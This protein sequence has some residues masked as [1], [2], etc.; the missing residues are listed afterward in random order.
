MKANLFIQGALCTLPLFVQAQEKPNI[1]FILADDMRGSALNFLGKESIHTPNINQLATDGVTFTNAH[2]MGGTSGAVSMPSRAMLMTG[3][4]LQNLN[5]QGSN[6]PESHTTMGEALQKGGYET[7]H[8]GKW[9]SDYKSF[10]RC[11]TGGDDIFF[12]GMADH[13]NVPLH[14]YRAD[15]SYGKNRPTILKPGSNNF[16]TYQ[17]GDHLYSGKHSVDIFTDAAIDYV[18]KQKDAE[19][20]FFMYVAYMSPH[21]PRSMPQQYLDQYSDASIQLPDN[22]MEKHPFD[23]G[24]LV[25]RDEVLAA[26][27]RVPTEVK[28]QIKSYYA[29]ITHLD[30]NIGR[31]IAQLKADGTYDNTIIVFAADNGLA[32]GQH[33]LLGKQNVYEHSVGVPLI[34]KQ[35]NAKE[36]RQNDALCYLIDVFPTLCD[37][38]NVA[39]PQ[40][41]EGI[42][43]TPA[44]HENKAVR[45][46]LYYTYVNYQ[47]A[48]SDGE[49]KL[50][51]YHV[52]GVRTTQLF[53]LKNDPMEKQNLAQEKKYKSKIKNLRKEMLVQRDVVADNNTAFWKNFEF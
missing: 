26:I 53:N 5:K 33:G 46:Y 41:V 38:A 10:N 36:A 21:D 28:E 30:D 44:L 17:T 9:H 15:G 22:Y 3:K 31:L 27:P 40:S 48:I 8:I 18:S 45:E 24:E 2:I 43:L 13:W 16:V 35:P 12:G 23:N 42:S 20:P 34:I 51:E 29:M 11:F 39:T 47:R 37:M 4:H 25:I 49:W 50:I 14:H 19:N 7:Y 6:I 52:K 1:I 32:V